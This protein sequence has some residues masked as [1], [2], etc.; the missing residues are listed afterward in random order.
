M[1]KFFLIA[2]L[3]YLFGFG[4]AIIFKNYFLNMKI[5]LLS[6]DYATSVTQTSYDLFLEILKNNSGVYLASIAGFMTFGF[7]TA[8]ST[9]YN[10]FVL[11]DVLVTLNRFFDN[12]SIILD[13]LLPHSIEI[14]G[15]IIS[16][17]LGFY[18][19]YFFAQH[20]FFK[21]TLNFEFKKVGTL[22]IIGYLIIVTS[23]LIES[24]VSAA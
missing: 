19:T 2:S 20:F 22:F 4:A 5:N 24:H 13:R 18:L 1:K 8:L 17:T 21:T 14:I 3:F 6:I 9:F 12:H 16:S 11:G 15:V 23:A 10:G 7:Y